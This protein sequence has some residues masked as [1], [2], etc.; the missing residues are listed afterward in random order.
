M[1]SQ[2][3]NLK[4]EQ[5]L[6]KAKPIVWVSLTIT[7]SLS[8]LG[9]I[10]WITNI[11]FFK[12][13]QPQWIPMNLITAICLSMAAIGLFMIIRKK[14]FNRLG[15]LIA[16]ILGILVC[17]IGLLTIADSANILGEGIEEF[18]SRSLAF[19][20]VLSHSMRMTLLTAIIIL[21]IGSAIVILA[22]DSQRSANIAHIVILPAAIG[23]YLISLRYLFGVEFMHDFLGAPIAINSGIALCAICVAIFFIRPDTWLM[24]VFTGKLIGSLMAKRLFPALIILPVMIGWLRIYGEKMGIFDSEVG[25][26]LVAITYT[27]CLIGLIWLS[28]KSAIGMEKKRLLA[29][30]E[31]HQSEQRLKFHF[32]NSPLAIVEWDADFIVTQWSKEAEHIFGWKKEETLGKPIGDLKL[33]FEEDI[34]IV[35]Q[36][37]ERLTSGKEQVVI[38]SNRNITKAGEIR[39]CM[40]SNSVLLDENGKM[41]SVLSLI[42]DITERKNKE[43]ELFKINR[44]LKA[45]GKSSQIMMHAIDESSFL[46]EVCN[47]IIEECGHTMI[48]IGYAEDND[49]KTVTPVVSAGY[50]EGYIEKLNVTWKDNERGRGP[51]GKAIRTGKITLCKIMLTN[52]D[53]EPWREEAIK[54]GYASSIAIPL[55]S[56]SKVLGAITIY[57]KD[58]D[59][60]TK[61]EEVLLSELANDVTFGI[62]LIRTS[63]A[64]KKAEAALRE[65]EDQFSKAF[66]LSPIGINIFRL[67]DSRVIDTNDAFLN[68]IGYSREEIIGHT[69]KELNLLVEQV[70]RDSWMKDLLNND[71][72]QNAEVQIRHKS[73]KIVNA[74]FSITRIESNGEA[75]GLIQAIDITDR[76]RM[77]AELKAS[78]ERVRL[79]LESI[80]SPKGD[81]TTLELAD[82]IDVPTIHSLMD[83]FN[84][85][86][87]IPMA[88]IDYKGK[89]IVQVGWQ[90]ICTK[91]HRVH[92]DTC[93]NCIDS[94]TEEIPEGEF[95]L[96][97]CKNGMWDTAIPIYIGKRYMGNLFLGQFLFEDE[98]I[99]Y[100]F[101]RLQAARYG[102][103]EKEYIAALEKVPRLSHSSL[104]NAIEFFL[105]LSY[106]ISQLS[107]SNINLARNINEHERMAH[108]LRRNNE[109]LDILSQT[110]SSLLSSDNPQKIVNGFCLKV[111]HF[112]DCHVFFN[113][114]FD[115]QKEKLH[116]NAYAGIPEN[117]IKKIEW[118]E[119]KVTDNDSNRYDWKNLV[120]KNILETPY[121]N[122]ELEKSFGITA[123]LS[124][125]LLSHGKI[126]GSL[127]FGSKSM[128]S[129]SNEDIS[130]MKAVTDQVAIA[131]TRMK[132]EK[133]LYRT[134]NY[135]ENLINFANVP[136]IVWNPQLQIQLFNIAFENLTGYS[137]N[138]VIGKKLDFL[139]PLN[140]IKEA[141]EKIQ[142]TISGDQW[143]TLE[144]PIQCKNKEVRIVLWNSANVYDTDN[145]TLIS[146]IAQGND[147]T[148]RK[149]AEEQIE[150]YTIDLK[151]SNTE[152]DKFFN[153]IAHDLKNP[154]T[155]LMGASEL[156]QNGVHK[157]SPEKIEILSKLMHNSAKSGYAILENLLEWSRSQIGNMKFISELVNLE[158]IISEIIFSVNMLACSKNI[159]IT[160][161]VN[162]EFLIHADINMLKTILRNLLMN[163]IKFTHPKGAIEIAAHIN[164]HEVLISVKDSGIGIRQED[165]GKLFRIDTQ[166][167]CVD[168]ENEK[169]TGLGLILCKE[170]IDKH[171]GKIWVESEF[172]KGSEFKFTIPLDKT[173]A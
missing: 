111:M 91:F 19:D 57:S 89:V 51:T 125:P 8:I 142:Q 114:L 56:N 122:S 46:K 168:T 127:S 149:K 164:D 9:L 12:S 170:F 126:I 97:K 59:S 49:E 32:D 54:R 21:S 66:H 167:I 80:L 17:I 24:K 158:T 135:L 78:E 118:L 133:E 110:V 130:L 156:L 140:I 103:D 113:Y 90:D 155:S 117:E 138:E 107:Y 26:I 6:N 44:T 171:H 3:I 82:I 36:T 7:F 106:S 74:L 109:R 147:I 67:A 4:T 88:I 68:L 100:N 129:F 71:S 38:S 95:K 145:K 45:L 65:S 73:G 47:V 102:F 173:K 132:N 11:A 139:F 34:P 77:E 86:F 1:V 18:L 50:E 33:I 119:V 40:W 141:K 151:N 160:T 55:I 29:E 60:F 61:S 41:A 115:E 116:L 92:P 96:Y 10:G 84:K 153:I 5:T 94:D 104:D 53:F 13:I 165:I 37:M 31:L 144:I 163:A 35:N 108:A 15:I 154:F 52:P 63:E 128:K 81:I 25:V 48:W 105:K 162:D 136:I 93:K 22:N 159:S 27:V 87:P 124:H 161:L 2:E 169:G 76:I 137:F 157:Y 28:A 62:N 121:S 98:S 70:D 83:N 72:I 23:S 79:K 14:Y 58:P 39:E 42:E 112:L 43:E 85:L 152:K 150:R 134:N 16:K 64:Q 99:N 148:A 131:F 123:Y 120:I 75:M 101:F 30:K 143:E 166:Y 172:G 20:T 69:P 146:T